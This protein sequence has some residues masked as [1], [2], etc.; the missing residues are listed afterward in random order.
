LV[1]T[2]EMWSY[3]RKRRRDKTGMRWHFVSRSIID[4]DVPYQ[5]RPFE[6]YFR[7]DDRTE[8]GPL[9]FEKRK[10]NPARNY[11]ALVFKIMNNAEFRRS[12]LDPDTKNVWRR[13]WK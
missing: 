7:N 3:E 11:E 9:R 6:L 10:D 4:P 1:S 13:S 8:F 2:N 5:E 12:V